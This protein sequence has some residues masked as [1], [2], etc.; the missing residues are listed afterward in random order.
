VLTVELEHFCNST[1]QDAKHKDQS[2][3]FVGRAYVCV[4]R[5]HYN[6][7]SPFDEI[8]QT[9]SLRR[10]HLTNSTKQSHSLGVNSHRK[11]QV[12]SYHL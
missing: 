12:S 1:Q 3:M 11:G 7:K 6:R 10:I 8:L 2:D 9:L 5:L 4:F